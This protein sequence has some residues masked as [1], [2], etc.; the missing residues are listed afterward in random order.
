MAKQRGERPEMVAIR[1]GM[2]VLA[3]DGPVGTVERVI[4]EEKTGRLIALIVRTDADERIEI[5]ASLVEVETSRDEVR[6]LASRASMSGGMTALTEVGDRLLLP[7]HEEVLIPVAEPIELGEVRIHKRVETVPSEVIADLQRDDIHIE[8]VPV[9]RQID[10]VPAPRN[11][12]DTIIIPVIEEVLVT[13]KRLVL[14]EEIRV[15]RR[16]VTEQV[17]VKGTVRREIVEIEETVLPEATAGATGPAART[18][19]S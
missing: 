16:R 3:S 5:P 19:R 4:T 14:R 18:T 13:E 8:R 11:E 10:A 9:D 2:T 1:T 12:G 6:L 17:P 15:T 7:V